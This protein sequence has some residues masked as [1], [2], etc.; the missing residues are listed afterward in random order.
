MT[1]P[2]LLT[3]EN[4]QKA[5]GLLCVPELHLLLGT[6]IN[7]GI[8]EKHFFL[9]IVDKLLSEF[10]NGVFPTKTGGKKFMDDFLKKVH[11][12]LLNTWL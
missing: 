9:G 4:D 6:E 3:G 2:P 5:L 1:N 12:C 8:Y 10:E 7:K 11:F